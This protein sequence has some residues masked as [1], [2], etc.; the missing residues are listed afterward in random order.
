MGRYLVVVTLETR[1]DIRNLDDEE[2][3]IEALRS[4]DSVIIFVNCEEDDLD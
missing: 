1:D 3:V 4:E 2:E